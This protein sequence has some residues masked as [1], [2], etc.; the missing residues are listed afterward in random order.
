LQHLPRGRVPAPASRAAGRTADRRGPRL[1]RGETQ[2]TPLPALGGVGG[3]GPYYIEGLEEGGENRGGTPF[4]AA[5]RGIGAGGRGG[6]TSLFW[7][8]AGR[9]PVPPPHLLNYRANVCALKKLG[10]THLVSISAVGSMR[11][12]I[13]PGHVVVVDQFIDLTKRRASTFFDDGLVA[14]V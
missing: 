7:P 9:G 4:R 10:A 12:H 6:G 8:R 2:K 14:H 13:A 3:S 11:E 5:T 1:R